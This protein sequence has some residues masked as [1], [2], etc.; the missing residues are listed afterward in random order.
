MLT[1]RGLNFVPQTD[2]VF[3]SLSVAENLAVAVGVLPRT[4]RPAALARV[5]ELFPLLR[6]RRRQRAG[7]LS[8]GQRKLVG[9]A[10]ALVT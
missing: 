5:H 1:E 6:E 3:P 2:N 7:T 8:G 9:L 10:R 4:E